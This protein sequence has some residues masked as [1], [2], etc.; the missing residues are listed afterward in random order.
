MFAAPSKAQN[1][2]VI[3]PFSRTWAWVSIPEPPR[4]R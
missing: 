3:R 4:S 2:K 1:M